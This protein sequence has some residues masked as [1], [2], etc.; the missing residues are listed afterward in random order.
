[1]I[2]ERLKK[3]RKYM[4]YTQDDLAEKLSISRSSLSLYEID[5]REPD[6]ETF[7]KI[8]DFFDVSLDYLNGR[9]DDP[10]STYHAVETGKRI[11]EENIDWKK[12]VYQIPDRKNNKPDNN[13]QTSEEPRENDRFKELIAED[14]TSS[15]D[16]ERLALL[17]ILANNDDLYFKV[18][19]IYDFAERQIRP[20]CLEGTIDLCSGSR[21]MVRLAFNLFNGFPA[22]IMDSFSC[23]DNDNFKLAMEAIQIRFNHLQLKDEFWEKLEKGR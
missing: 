21:R 8:A 4:G 17:W 6:S 9:T 22:D 23:L 15:T 2:G 1:M 19:S 18:N 12:E 16:A 3:L 10:N 13:G 5:K 14:H 20:E 11:L 7:N